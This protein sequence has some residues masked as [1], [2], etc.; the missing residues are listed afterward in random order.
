MD[1]SRD[2][3]VGEV[4]HEGRHGSIYAGLRRSD[5]HP[6]VLKSYGAPESAE[7][8]LAALRRAAGDGIVAGLEVVRDGGRTL[9]ALDR[10]GGV[11]LDRWVGAGTPASPQAFLEIG[12]QLARALSRVHAARLIHRGVNPKNVIVDPD[13]LRVCLIDFSLARPLGSAADKGELELGGERIGTD[14]L[15]I[16]PE[17]TG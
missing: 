1:T 7:R 3:S 17:Q 15:Y 16:S 5:G 11:A 8:E 14:F 10:V 9:L 6:V 13:T 2:F 4:L 12:I